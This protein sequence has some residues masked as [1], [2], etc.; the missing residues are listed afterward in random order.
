MNPASH[1]RYIDVEK[2]SLPVD[3]AGDPVLDEQGL[4]HKKSLIEHLN[5]SY[6]AGGARQYEYP[7]ASE[8]ADKKSIAFLSPLDK[9]AEFISTSRHKLL[10]AMIKQ[11]GGTVPPPY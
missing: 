6:W 3:D 9:F 2:S 7:E 1:S 4:Q 11:N 10:D 5:S 8:V